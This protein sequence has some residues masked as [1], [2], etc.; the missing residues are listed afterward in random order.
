MKQTMADANSSS[1]VRL[2]RFGWL[3]ALAVIA[4][5]AAIVAFI[6]IY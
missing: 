5:I 2:S 6:I 4:Y 3:L 1:N